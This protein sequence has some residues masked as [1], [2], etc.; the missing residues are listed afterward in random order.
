MTFIAFIIW[1]F[2]SIKEGYFLGATRVVQKLREINTVPHQIFLAFQPGLRVESRQEL[3]DVAHMPRHCNQLPNF[4]D[5]LQ[6]KT[7]T[8]SEHLSLL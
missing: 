6:D 4:D 8:Q 5:Y 7:Y 3:E 2:Y 1:K